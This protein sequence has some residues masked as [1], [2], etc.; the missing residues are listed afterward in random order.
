MATTKSGFTLGQR[1][2]RQEPET[3]SNPDTPKLK[4][5]FTAHKQAHGLHNAAKQ[6][7]P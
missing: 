5:L 7:Q 6:R 2:W 3:H 1:K 4:G